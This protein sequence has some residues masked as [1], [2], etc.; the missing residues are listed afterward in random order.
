MRGQ[1]GAVEGAPVQGASWAAPGGAY[2]GPGG[3]GSVRPT[4]RGLA[5]GRRCWRPLPSASAR[6]QRT[7]SPC[8]LT[9]APWAGGADV[10]GKCRFRFLLRPVARSRTQP[11]ALVPQQAPLLP[12]G[13]SSLLL[14]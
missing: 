14:F 13:V 5:P 3:P 11:P 2:R 12:S 7:P 6:P 10:L 1:V 4:H 9:P 8:A